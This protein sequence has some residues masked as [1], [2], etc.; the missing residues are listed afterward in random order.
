MTENKSNPE[1]LFQDI[2]EIVQE[3]NEDTKPTE[4]ES[5]CMSC[6]QNGITK[7]LLTRI[8]HWRDIVLMS[9]YCEHCGFNNNEVQ[10]AGAI[11]EKGCEY[12]CEIHDKDDLNRQLV[13]SETASIKLQELD[14]EIPATTK[15]GRLSTV[16]GVVSSIVED[17][18]AAQPDRKLTD[19]DTYNK[20][21]IIINK[22]NGYLENKEN[23]S[24][25]VDDPC[26]NSYI[27]NLLAPKPD[28][29]LHIRHYNRTREM[30]ISLGL[31][32]PDE[33]YNED[34]DETREDDKDEISEVMTFPANC[35]HCNAPSDTKMHLVDIPHFKEVVIMSTVCDSCGYKSNEVKAGGPIA[36]KGKKITLKMEEIEDLS[37]DIL[38][39][40]TCSLLIP[41]IELE[42]RSGTLGGRFTTVEG[43]L[44]QVYEELQEKVPFV[45]GDGAQQERKASFEKFLTKLNKVITGETLPIHLVLDDPLSN[46]YLQN[47]NAPDPDPNMQI[48]I[49]ERSW[50]QNEFLGLNDVVL[51]N[52]EIK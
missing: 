21:E 15:R 39:S 45:S 49:Y 26:G 9:F 46:S 8:P 20:I 13:K 24:I 16:E 47:L 50:D 38:K 7:L 25:S 1:K 11:A 18:S 27:E 19:E 2:G 48:E 28:P 42:L 51:E 40:E 33:A 44:R 23:F 41:E 36:P 29:K 37:R 31:I 52:Y 10:F 3:D 30:D 35:S 32:I 43:L 22:L 6:G 34:C 5:Y 4:I 17:L 14:L 12:T